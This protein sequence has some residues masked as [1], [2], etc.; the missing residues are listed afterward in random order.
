MLKNVIYHVH[1]IESVK[2]TYWDHFVIS[3]AASLFYITVVVVSFS[4]QTIQQY[5][6]FRAY[7]SRSLMK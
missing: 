6:N 2:L 3:L 1:P 7:L 4:Y 5:A